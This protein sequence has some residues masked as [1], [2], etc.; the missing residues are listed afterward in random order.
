MIQIIDRFLR[1]RR[2]RKICKAQNYNCS[3]CIYHEYVF[4]G[5]VFRGTRCRLEMEDE[6]DN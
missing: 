6:N 2:L 3:E 1:K 5:T 4:E